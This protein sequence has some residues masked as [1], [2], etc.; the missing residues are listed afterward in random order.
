VVERELREHAQMI[1][2]WLGDCAHRPVPLTGIIRVFQPMVADLTGSDL[3]EV[4]WKLASSGC[5]RRFSPQD[6]DWVALLQAVG[7]RDGARMATSARRLLEA[8]PGLS[9]PSQRYLIAAGMLGSIAQQDP[10]AARELWSRYASSLGPAD[11][12]LLRFLV[13]RSRAEPPAN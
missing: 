13:A 10:A 5:P 6:R 1:S 2:Q 9:V 11:D 12:L 4:W 7:R 3:D 8:E